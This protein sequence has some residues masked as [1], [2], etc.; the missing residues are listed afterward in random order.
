MFLVAVCFEWANGGENLRLAVE[1][2]EM[3]KNLK[4]VEAG[5]EVSSGSMKK[6]KMMKGTFVN[7]S[8]KKILGFAWRKMCDRIKAE[9]GRALGFGLDQLPTVGFNGVRL[10]RFTSSPNWFVRRWVMDLLRVLRDAGL[11]SGPGAGPRFSSDPGSASSPE[12]AEGPQARLVTSPSTVDALSS[13]ATGDFKVQQS[14][15]SQVRY[16]FADGCVSALAVTVDSVL[17]TVDHVKSHMIENLVNPSFVFPPLPTS[18]SD[19]L[20]FAAMLFAPTT[21]MLSSASLDVPLK[22]EASSPA[23]VGFGVGS[24]EHRIQSTSTRQ[25][26]FSSGDSFSGAAALGER[27]RLS[28][29]ASSVSKSFQSYY[30]RAREGRAMHLDESLFA[31]SVA[32]NEDRYC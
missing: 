30:R 28:T 2:Y 18:S 16:A 5:S 10:G 15:S 21:K 12:D 13:F 23:P 20:F 25:E 6:A 32:G 11:G 29:T 14:G 27:L 7:R 8:Q 3:E 4:R 24:V 31:E 19:P 9:V 1:C 17:V 22:S 26:S